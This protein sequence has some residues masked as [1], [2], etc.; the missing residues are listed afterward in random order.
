VPRQDRAGVG[1]EAKRAGTA[2]RLESGRIVLAQVG[3]ESVDHLS[4]VP[5][6]VLMSGG[7]DGDGEGAWAGRGYDPHLRAIGDLVGI[8]RRGPRREGVDL[9]RDEEFAFLSEAEAARLRTFVREAFAERGIEV[10]GRTGTR[11]HGLGLA[12][13]PLQS[14]GRMPHRQSRPSELADAGRRTC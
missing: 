12:L 1:V 3:A 6:R 2:K 5:D 14:R 9:P 11:D 7:Q 8:F 4:P 13:R 10:T